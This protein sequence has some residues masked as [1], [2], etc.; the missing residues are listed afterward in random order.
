MT[1]PAFLWFFLRVV[2]TEAD[3][4]RPK[5]LPSPPL[6]LLVLLVDVG[7]AALIS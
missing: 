3:D 7:H 1:L 6:S 4:G 2:V 5:G